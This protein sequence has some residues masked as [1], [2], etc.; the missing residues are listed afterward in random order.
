[1]DIKLFD[2]LEDFFVSRVSKLEMLRENTKAYIIA[3]LSKAHKLPNL[4]N[5]SL[6]IAFSNARAR[7][8]FVEYQ[9]L[10]IGFYL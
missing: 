8:N 4:S 10:V 1:M 3:T 2:N 5:E 6:T 9:N 7:H